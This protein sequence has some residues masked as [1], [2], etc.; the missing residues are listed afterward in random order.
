MYIIYPMIVGYIGERYKDMSTAKYALFIL[1]V[2]SSIYVL[3]NLLDGNMRMP[4]SFDLMICSSA[5]LITTAL[6][7]F[8]KYYRKRKVV[9]R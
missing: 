4:D 7:H 5:L 1:V 8:Q 6:F 3:I 9:V 2:L